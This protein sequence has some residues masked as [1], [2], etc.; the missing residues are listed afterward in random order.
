MKYFQ[1]IHAPWIAEILPNLKQELT[2]NDARWLY[3]ETRQKSV[4]VQRHTQSI[5][6]RGAKRLPGDT[7]HVREIQDSIDTSSASLFPQSMACL[8]RIAHG[9]HAALCRAL[10]VR[11]A[12]RSVV[13]PHTDNGSY[14]AIRDRYHLVIESPGGSILRCGGEEVTM[15]NGELWRFDN[16]ILHDSENASE[17]WRTHLIFDLLALRKSRHDSLFKSIRARFLRRI[18]S[19]RNRV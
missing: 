1:Q 9:C 6:L 12:P 2:L 18:G 8:R 13:Y 17:E 5:I 3:N 19:E 4:R 10:Y 11:L 16:K 14:Y 15:R 7:T